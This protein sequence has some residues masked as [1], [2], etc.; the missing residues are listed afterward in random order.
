LKQIRKQLTY[1]NVMSTIAVFLLIGGG[2]AFAASKSKINGNRIK[3][4]TIKTG[5]LAKE[6][7]KTGKIKQGAVTESRIADTAVTTNKLG[8]LAVTSGKLADA[9]VLTDKL[10]DE[11]VTSGKLGKD[12]V[13]TDKIAGEAVTT[14]K[15]ANNAVGQTKLATDSVGAAQFKN[16]ITRTN[17]VV[18][19]TG[20]SEAVSVSCQAGE[21]AI[22]VGT[23]WGV[24]G[25]DR[26]T[27]YAHLVGN[28]ATARGNQ[29][30]GGN[31]TF[32]VEVYC[33]PV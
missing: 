4:G 8:D 1:A 30:T 7:V 6:A 15:I 26:Y 5:K 9:S 27:N 21:Q 3:A 18:I 17:S 19:A 23:S 33:L 31:Q 29:F 10:A 11:S 13:T 16:L 32:I 2:A 22:G 12:S 14:G 28:G 24:F 20:G 25:S